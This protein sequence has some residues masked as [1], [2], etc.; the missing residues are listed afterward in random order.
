MFIGRYP[1]K[2]SPPNLDGP[3]ESSGER[4]ASDHFHTPSL[5]LFHKSDIRYEFPLG[6]IANL[7]LTSREYRSAK[8]NL[9][10]QLDFTK[11]VFIILIFSSAQYVCLRQTKLVKVYKRT[12]QR[13]RNKFEERFLERESITLERSER[14]GPDQL[15]RRLG[16]NGSNKASDPHHSRSRRSSSNAF[17]QEDP[18]G[19][20]NLPD[21]DKIALV[22]HIFSITFLTILVIKYIIAMVLEH[23]SLDEYHYID[24]YLIGRTVLT[25]S[26]LSATKYWLFSSIVQQ[27]IWEALMLIFKPKIKMDSLE[28]ILTNLSKVISWEPKKDE[29]VR[30]YS[31][32]SIHLNVDEMSNSDLRRLSRVSNIDYYNHDADFSYPSNKFSHE[33]PSI[34]TSIAHLKIPY[35]HHGTDVFLLRPNRTAQVWMMYQ[36]YSF[37]FFAFIIISLLFWTLSTIYLAIHGSATRRGFELTNNLCVE[38][39]ITQYRSSNLTQS[40]KISNYAHIYVP[41]DDYP[42][43]VPVTSTILP[44]ENLL[45][46]SL[47]HKLRIALTVFESTFVMFNGGLQVL[48]QLYTCSIIVADSII[49]I[50]HCKRKLKDYIRSVGWR[51]D[52]GDNEFLSLNVVQN[53]QLS[54]DILDDDSASSRCRMDKVMELQALVYDLFYQMDRN[55]GFITVFMPHFLMAW[56]YTGA[57]SCFLQLTPAFSGQTSMVLECFSFWLYYGLYVVVILCSISTVESYSRKLY[58]Y[59]ASAMVYDNSIFTTKLNWIVLM[60][61]YYPMPY[62]CYKMLGKTAISFVFILQV[63]YI[64][65]S[66]HSSIDSNTN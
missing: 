43:D 30:R 44:L 59:I 46:H 26:M 42:L 49:H 7:S 2:A 40:S 50:Q 15:N 25:G 41:H 34:H 10:W 56:L 31:R 8:M 60:S 21:Y 13:P 63:R 57:T 29:S 18:E 27:L 9:S 28:F 52:G 22:Y 54:N 24:C 55:N 58:K 1:K 14:I 33:E 19:I 12:N 5:S 37:Y 39:I 38:W 4:R 47:Y 17:E 53:T 66:D 3:I 23:C 32:N 20:S 62:H 45:M 64:E 6:A 48:C 51:L 16:S 61:Q 35:L 36:R 11:F 65:S